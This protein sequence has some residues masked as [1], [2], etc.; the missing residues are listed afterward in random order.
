MSVLGWLM[1]VINSL[2]AAPMGMT[3]MPHSHSMHA[4]VAAVSEP[5]CHHQVEVAP[6]KPAG[7]CCGDQAGCCGGP[8]SHH[9][10]CAVLCVTA[11]PPAMARGLATTAITAGYVMPLQINTPT[12]ATTPPLRPPAV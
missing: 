11:L 3:G 5:H 6:A 9:C 4:T 8:T 12:L 2:A 7:F 10:A 1:L